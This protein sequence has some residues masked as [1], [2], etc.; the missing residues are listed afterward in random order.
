MSGEEKKERKVTPIGEAKWAHLD[1]PKAPFEGKGNPKY[2]IDVVFDPN[3]EAWKKWAGEVLAHL[4]S[5]PEQTNKKTGEKMLRQSPLKKEF[6]RDD[7]ATGRYYVT[8][9]TS[10]KFKPKVFDKFGKELPEGT[11]VGNGSK[12][13]VS[14]LEND[15]EAFGGGINFYLNAVQ[16]IELVEYGIHSASSFGFDVEEEPFQVDVDPF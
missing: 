12:V 10:D 8:F 1:K 4:K 14:Y 3:D 2:Q 15:F 11:L 5:L 9:K 13:R 7:M 16:V 6:G